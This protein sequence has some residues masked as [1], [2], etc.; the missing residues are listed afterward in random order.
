VLLFLPRVGAAQELVP[1]G[2]VE[3]YEGQTI[4]VDLRS[5]YKVPEGA[6]GLVFTRNTVGGIEQVVRVAELTVLSVSAGR[7]RGRVTNQVGRVSPK[8]GFSVAFSPIR[9][10]GRAGAAKRAR[11]RLYSTPSGATVT[12]RP[13][14]ST[15]TGRLLSLDD[16]ALGATPVTDSL[17]PGRYRLKIQKEGYP[18][19]RRTLLLRPD[20]MVTDSVR[21]RQEG[22]LIVTVRPDTASIAIDGQP[23]GRGGV[24]R[25][26]A[27]GTHT[28]RAQAPGYQARSETVSVSAGGIRT[29]TLTLDRQQEALAITSTP[30]SARVQVDGT[31][32]GRTPLTVR[33]PP[34]SYAV[35][36]SADGYQTWTDTV[37][38]TRDREQTL[39]AS[40]DRRLGTLRVA[41]MPDSARVEIDGTAVGRTPLTL[42]RPPGTYDVQVTA[43]YYEA[44]TETVPVEAEEKAV[45]SAQLRRPV[46]VQLA[47]SHGPGVQN[48]RLQREEDRMVVRYDLRGEEDAYDVALRLSDER[49]Q[50]FPT[51][52]TGVRGDVGEDVTA[53]AERTIRWAVLKD[54]PRG[55]V[56]DNY[57]LRIAT[58][59]QGG[60]GVL[61]V[62]GSA[63]VGGG[64]TTAVLMLGGSDGGGGGG[65]GNGGGED[66]GGQIPTPPSPP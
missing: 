29:L 28:V 58:D 6:T 18:A 50:S 25:S 20:T 49:G 45:V 27:A 59:P 62:L 23:V 15:A 51:E 38:V 46:E 21:L 65:G 1:H 37:S 60:N 30:D 12:A 5:L 43:P 56:G 52:L 54:Y 16:R 9:Q 39:E 2:T 10:A 53:G 41:S 11:L 17:L 48:V 40:L 8:E 35:R 34:G 4:E 26:L 13:L 24:Q 14:R 47:A 66:P 55:I 3:Q 7:V 19:I 32:V 64:V 44:Y 22:T 36:V 42:Q 63:L 57:R 61:Y 31:S 33:R